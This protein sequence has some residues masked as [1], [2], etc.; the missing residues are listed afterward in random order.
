[1]AYSKPI[2]L[3]L[4][5][6]QNPLD[7]QKVRDSLQDKEYVFV[8]TTELFNCLDIA[9]CHHPGVVLLDFSPIEHNYLSVLQFLQFLD[10]PAIIFCDRAPENV[11]RHL[12]YNGALATFSSDCDPLQLKQTVEQAL[13]PETNNGLQQQRRDIHRGI[14]LGN[15][16]TGKNTKLQDIINKAI[17]TAVSQMGGLIG[18][19]VEYEP[20]FLQALPPLILQEKLIQTLGKE[21]VAVAQLDFKG[22]L[23]GSAQILFSKEAADALV[24]GLMEGEE[25]EGEEL[26]AMK[27]DIMG[28]I[29]NLAINGIV[30]TF[31]NTLNYKLGYVVPAYFEGSAEEIFQ[32][33]NL[34]LKST[35]I[36]F[37]S[38]FKIIELNVE[39]DFILFFQARL[40]LDLLFHV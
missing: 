13:Y 12:H 21:W 4:I 20:P 10:I 18:C 3:I 17:G 35:V 32:A 14:D 11:I 5:A 15:F 25:V 31:S 33:I 36:L 38:H 30:G 26:K 23:S 6:K 1:M 22:N 29:G 8:E 28:E 40:L 39:G 24:A 2:S 9:E 7:N 34:S 19:E 16:K 37:S 27:A